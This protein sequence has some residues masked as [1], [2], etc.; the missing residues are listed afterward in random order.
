MGR[1]CEFV[2]DWGSL[3]IVA[4]HCCESTEWRGLR[5]GHCAEC[6]V[7]SIAAGSIVAAPPVPQALARL[8][9]ASKG[10]KGRTCQ[11]S[12]EKYVQMSHV[13]YGQSSLVSE[14]AM[15]SYSSST[16]YGTI[17]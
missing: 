1:A 2:D 12:E 9:P 4:P 6:S 14:R 16:S 5:Y 15:D 17:G 13:S 8:V 11:E 3:Y 10:D 7:L